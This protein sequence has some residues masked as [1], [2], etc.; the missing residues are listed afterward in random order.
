MQPKNEFNENIGDIVHD[1]NE[2]FQEELDN[3]KT[4]GQ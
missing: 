1:E 3:E 4:G 2:V